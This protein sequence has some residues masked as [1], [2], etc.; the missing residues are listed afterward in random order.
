MANPK[1][2]TSRTHRDQ[3]RASSWRLSPPSL[4]ECPQCHET[5]MPH[6]ICPSCGYYRGREIVKQE[7]AAK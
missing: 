2:R 6:R 3:R 1:N 7:K 4:A 5:K